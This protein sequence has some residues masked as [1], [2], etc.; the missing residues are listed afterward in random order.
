[1]HADGQPTKRAGPIAPSSGRYRTALSVPVFDPKEVEL[2]LILW[3]AA[4]LVFL[5]WSLTAWILSGLADWSASLVAAAL[6]G[7]VA[8]ELGQW[9]TWAI[10]R[11][12]SPAST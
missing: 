8:A 11:L 1:M 3:P 9:A 4:V 6:G 7:I 2:A 5:L 12:V 10:G